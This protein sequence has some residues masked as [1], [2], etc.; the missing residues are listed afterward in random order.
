M[1]QIKHG[2]VTTEKITESLWVAKVKTFE[3]LKAEIETTGNSE[4]NAY[5]KL[6]NFIQSVE[7]PKKIHTSPN[8]NKTYHF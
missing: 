1:S 2:S 5:Y 4:F 8:V 7:K 6:M 3:V